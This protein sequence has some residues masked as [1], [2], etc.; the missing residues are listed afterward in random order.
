MEKKFVTTQGSPNVLIEVVQGDLRLKGQEELEV[1]AKASSAEDLSLETRGEQIVISSQGDLS[2]RVPLN[3]QVSILTVHGNATAKALDGNL[4]FDTV[5]GDLTLRGVGPTQ[6]NVV[7]GELAAKN[8]GGDFV[9]NRI[10][11]DAEVRDIQ[12]SFSVTE[13][14]RGNLRLD[15]VN[16]D[17]NATTDGNLTLRIDPAPG[18]TYTFQAKGN[19]FCRLS[20]D[21]SVELCVPKANKVVVNLPDM[22]TSAPIQTPYALTL[23]EGDAELTLSAAGN[24][25]IDSHA[26]D[27]DLDD[28]DLEINA[29]VDGMADSIGL[30]IEQQ[31]EAQMRMVEENLNAQMFNLTNRLGASRLTEEQSR[32]VEERVRQAQERIEQKLASAQRKIEQKS[33]AAERRKRIDIR[34][35]AGD[36]PVS[37]T[38]TGHRWGIPTPPIPP[39]PP[40]DPVS[41]EERLMILRMLEQKKI[42][43]DQAEQLLSAL[44]G[45]EA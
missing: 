3:A 1:V 21:S 6:V 4:L 44:E 14:V 12:G 31:I 15:D 27:W 24:V 22:Q 28:F 30:Q 38:R 40:S 19:I 2:V 11:G 41:E 45:K 9:I 32:R 36:N 26:P 34:I 10:E 7:H 8:I 20:E 23:G 43:L 35:K 16:A 5:H 13:I 29:E 39:T 18:Q 42:N 37:Q 25:V 33:R 17:A